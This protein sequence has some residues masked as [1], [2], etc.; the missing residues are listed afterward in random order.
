MAQRYQAGPVVWVAVIIITLLSLYF[1]QGILWLIIPS[2]LAVI[3][4]YVTEPIVENLMHAGISRSRAAT[5][6]MGAL[7]LGML[8]IAVVLFPSLVQGIES[9]RQ[10]I[11]HYLNGGTRLLVHTLDSL[12]HYV[13]FC[14]G[15]INEL[16]QARWEDLVGQYIGKYMGDALLLVL[17]WIPSLVLVPYLAFFIL[18]DGGKLKRF[19]VQ[20]IPNAFFER[21]L[22]LFHRVDRQV[23]RYFRGLM[24]LTILDAVCLG[25]GLWFLGISSFAL[26][27]IITAVLAWIP[28]IGSILGCLIVLMVAATDYPDSSWIAYGSVALFLAVRLLDDFVFL[29][30]TI[31][32]S[33]K[34]H[35][36]VTV[37]MIFAGGAVAGISGLL[38]VMPVLGVVLV[39][40]Q[41]LGQLLTDE[42]VRARHAH[43]VQLRRR[44]VERDLVFTE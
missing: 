9:W 38:L 24:L 20:A 18:R 39:I 23:Q 16:K 22:L 42:R 4:Y 8:L 11:S 1:F 44:R 30:N 41:V 40:G 19:I 2:L 28:Y 37:L 36:V 13:P 7:M 29:P 33:L 5:I 21:A 15:I 12:Q 26:L 17:H 43:S 3:L 6:V 32:R 34:V 35:P 27:G 14:G 10:T 31:G 25:A